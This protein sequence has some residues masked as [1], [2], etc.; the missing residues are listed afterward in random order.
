MQFSHQIQEQNNISRFIFSQHQKCYAKNK[1][2]KTSG[3]R[4]RLATLDALE[5]RAESVFVA[6]AASV[7]EHLAL[8]GFC[9]IV[10]EQDGRSTGS[11]VAREGA[12]IA[13]WSKFGIFIAIK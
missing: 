9:V 6:S 10:P 11:F 12:L 13:C 8:V 7:R 3:Q 5:L 2:F 4:M 1:S